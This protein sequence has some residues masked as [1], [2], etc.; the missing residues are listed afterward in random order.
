MK[1]SQ[2]MMWLFHEEKKI[3]T[4]MKFYKNIDKRVVTIDSI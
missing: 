4:T 1:Y 2:I 3:K